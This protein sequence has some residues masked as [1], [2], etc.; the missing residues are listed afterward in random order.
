MNIIVHLKNILHQSEIFE[1]FSPESVL[2]SY[3]ISLTNGPA[4]G[5]ILGRFS[6][7]ISSVT[8]NIFDGV[9][10]KVREGVDSRLDA[11]EMGPLLQKIKEYNFVR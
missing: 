2:I 8:G 7:L 5:V 11:L 6:V 1:I 3:N 10:L 4:A 9:L